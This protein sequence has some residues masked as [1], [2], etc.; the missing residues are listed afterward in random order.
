M[1][2]LTLGAGALLRV[3]ALPLAAY[4]QGGSPELFAR[5]RQLQAD[6]CRYRARAQATAEDLGRVLVS[7]AGLSAAERSK[8]LSLRR[9]LHRGGLARTD[10]IGSV[11]V[12]AAREAPEAD[13]VT[14][15][16]SLSHWASELRQADEDLIKAVAAE[17]LRLL[18]LPWQVLGDHPAGYRA[19]TGGDVTIYA[20]I[21]ARLATGEPWTTKRM[22]QRSDYLWRMLTRA[23]TRATPRGWLA[24]VCPLTTAGQGWAAGLPVAVTDQAA[25][26]TVDNLDEVRAGVDALGSLDQDRV[27]TVSRAP[28]AWCDAEHVRVWALRGEQRTTLTRV[29][30]RRTRALDAAWAKLADG[31]RPV[32]SL[33][34]EL[35][36]SGAAPAETVRRF[37]AHLVAVGAL[38][39]ASPPR[40]V[41]SG[42]CRVAA[43][44]DSAGAASGRNSYS[45]VYR[46]PAVPL[47][48]AHGAELAR[49][50]GLALRVMACVDRGAGL[51]R[52]G[53]PAAVQQA[54]RPLLDVVADC[55]N[56][57]DDLATHVH[58]HDWQVPAG[59]EAGGDA[60]YERLHA[61]LTA[62]WPAG[63]GHG[64]AAI[65]LD[66]ALLDGCG[67]PEAGLSWPTDVLLRPMAAG[68]QGPLAA[69]TAVSY[70]GVLDARFLPALSGF[71]ASL[72]QVAAYRAFLDQLSAL[73]G[74][75]CVEL[76]IPPL[77]RMAA[78]AVRRP[79]YTSWWTG[80]P[81]WSGYFDPGGP[82]PT[83][84][85]PLAQI[86]VRR[87]GDRVIAEFDGSPIW[88]LT[89]TARVARAPWTVV[90]ALLEHASPQSSR[91]SWRQL[92]YS[93]PA[94]PDRDY[95]P[96]ITVDGRIVLTAAQWRV[97]RAEF[98]RPDD[99]L[100]ERA[101]A[102][103]SVRHARSLPRW[104]SVTADA[105]E[106][107]V[108]LD[109]DSLQALR[110]IDRIDRRHQTLLIAELVP[111]PDELPVRDLADPVPAGHGAELLLRLP[112]GTDAG[113]AAAA[114]ASRLASS[115]PDAGMAAPIPDSVLP[116]SIT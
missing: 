18:G 36:G 69:L 16:A 112:F 42:W 67:L 88:P 87:D 84:Y 14:R 31:P 13:L 6:S 35:A 115:R 5:L 106:E 62:R 100:V 65:N 22:R 79:A 114:V 68:P 110:Y 34:A 17:R 71:G 81:D 63:T 48:Q 26:E 96:R 109:L 103:A 58:R 52:P 101:R 73:T 33:V 24:H 91:Q 39:A 113:A 66:A 89:H 72:P 97:P 12:V 59:A 53:L 54:R 86:T 92:T 44:P 7:R 85:L 64:G 108:V 98:G 41:R 90:R 55:V 61:W 40:I 15:L 76:L 25:V 95:V 111:G 11:S 29:R 9:V 10:A 75:Q 56:G 1:N 46:K 37:L 94:W 82:G 50:V 30:L 28:L 21:A 47:A 19:L 20:D 27:V 2:S 107:A 45:D 23:S 102:L 70:A 3:A 8:V 77:S 38:Q 57:A 93:L 105:D 60:G 51:A 74:V 78:N 80:D 116:V 104:V 32:E 43:L 83:R 99:V 49:A 4:E